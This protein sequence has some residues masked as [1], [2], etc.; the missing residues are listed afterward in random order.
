M[1][2]K[3]HLTTKYVNL[4]VLFVESGMAGNVFKKNSSF[5]LHIWNTKEALK[6]VKKRQHRKRHFSFLEIVKTFLTAY[7]SWSSQPLKRSSQSSSLCLL[8]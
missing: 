1:T 6:E 7:I 8:L 3:L 2:H 4:T 5:F